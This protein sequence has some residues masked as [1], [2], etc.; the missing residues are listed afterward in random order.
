MIN[1][2]LD[3]DEVCSYTDYREGTPPPEYPKTGTDATGHEKAVWN[4]LYEVE[5]PEMPVSI[6][7]LG[8]IYGV[9]VT[10]GKALVRMTLTYTG[11]P[12]RD[13][14]MNDVRCAAETAEGVDR[15]EVE[16]EYSPPWSVEMVTEG[17]K[18]QL[19]EFGLSV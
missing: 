4:A 13:M 17:G 15:A 5:D 8:L 14:L 9:S 18:R 16:L 7:D 2:P 10:E 3:T 11:C 1:A 19:R 12:A 6:V